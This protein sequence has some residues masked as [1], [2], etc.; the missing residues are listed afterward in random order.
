MK[1][2]ADPVVEGTVDVGVKGVHRGT[3]KSCG[4]VFDG[5]VRMNLYENPFGPAGDGYTRTYPGGKTVERREMRIRAVDRA[6]FKPWK[7][8]PDPAAHIKRQRPL[9][10]QQSVR[11]WLHA[12]ANWNTVLVRPGPLGIVDSVIDAVYRSRLRWIGRG[13]VCEVGVAA[14]VEQNADLVVDAAPSSVRPGIIE[15]PISVDE[16]KCNATVRSSTQETVTMK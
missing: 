11:R 8:L 1:T 2:V 15:S 4:V 12:D 14:S 10:N 5:A 6:V 9:N 3:E 13:G 7:H 16:A